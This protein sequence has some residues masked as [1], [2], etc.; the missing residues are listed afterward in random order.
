[1]SGIALK[2]YS[3]DLPQGAELLR[4]ERASLNGRPLALANTRDM[5]ADPWQQSAQGRG[6]YLASTNLQDFAIGGA[7]G[8]GVVQVFVSLIPRLDSI[9]LP[10]AVGALYH[11]AIRDGA[12]FELLSTRSADFYDANAAAVSLAF[13]R[14]A[15]DDA[16]VDVWRSHTDRLSR[17]R[18][19][20]L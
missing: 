13:F 20:W 6:A 1:M 14:S 17:S 9:A 7:P 19:A 3:F 16:C 2:D 12:K 18:V 15:I 11:E 8:G 10:D 4:I 5:Q